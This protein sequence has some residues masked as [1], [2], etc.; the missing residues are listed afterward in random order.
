MS[1]RDIL[2]LERVNILDFTLPQR[3][4]R[5][6]STQIAKWGGRYTGLYGRGGEFG[7]LSDIAGPASTPTILG[8]LEV[9]VSGG[10]LGVSPGQLLSYPNLITDLPS[11]ATRH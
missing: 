5:R 3:W 8:G 9:A 1:I 11:F 4:A 7:G 6:L 2:D 10:G